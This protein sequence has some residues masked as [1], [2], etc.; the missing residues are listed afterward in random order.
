MKADE[1]I[2]SIPDA[3]LAAPENPWRLSPTTAGSAS[4]KDVDHRDDEPG[5]DDYE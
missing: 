4:N 1:R 2:S 3:I 5:D